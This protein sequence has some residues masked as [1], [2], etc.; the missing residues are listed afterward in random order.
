[1]PKGIYQKSEKE[2]QRLRTLNIGR[3]P[4]NKGKKGVQIVS[5]ATRAKL[6]KIRKGNKN[7]LGSRR[8]KEYRE[9]MKEWLPRGENHWNWRG[10]IAKDRR[11]G[12]KYWQWRS[13]IFQRDNWTCQT[14]EKRGCYLEV[15]HIKSWANYPKLRYVEENC[16]TLCKECHKLTDNYTGKNHGFYQHDSD[17][18]NIETSEEN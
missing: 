12:Q 5:E 8:T 18:E 14:C 16:V 10:G 15:H 3:E 7:A 4:W 9:K 13:N 1:M 11:T 17:K 6:K 2:K